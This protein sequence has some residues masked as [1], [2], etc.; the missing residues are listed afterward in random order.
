MA[1]SNLSGPLHVSGGFVGDLTGDTAG[2]HTGPVAGNTTGL[3]LG[4]ATEYAESGAIA[5]TDKLV[6]LDATAGALAM[7]LADG[8]EG[9]VMYIKCTTSV[10]PD[11]V[12]TPANLAD[13][14]TLTFD[15]AGEV[16]VLIF[17]GTEW[18]IIY[19]TSTLA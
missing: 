19:N 11:A 14:A 13:G 9:Q 15:A 5:L 2:T 17:D 10:T 3:S 12:V 4:P 6:L 18:Q 7:T 8:A 1:R 16:A